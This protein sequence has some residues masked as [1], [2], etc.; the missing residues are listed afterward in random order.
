M[1][2][3]T[4]LLA[5]VVALVGMCAGSEFVGAVPTRA[6]PQCGKHVRLG[7]SHCRHCRHRFT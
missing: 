4:A 6:C 5:V 2:P 7:I 1:D 3:T